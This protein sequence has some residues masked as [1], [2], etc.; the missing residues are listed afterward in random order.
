MCGHPAYGG[1]TRRENIECAGA[2]R[3]NDHPANTDHDVVDADE[4]V[5]TAA[6]AD[7]DDEK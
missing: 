3:W 7:D 2:F 1:G 5:A 4:A 6:A